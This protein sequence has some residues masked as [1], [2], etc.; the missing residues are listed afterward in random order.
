MEKK[1]ILVE[2]QEL[3]E[4]MKAND[5]SL[6]EWH[7]LPTFGGP[8]IEDTTGKWSWDATHYIE[9]TCADD[10]Q[11]VARDEGGEDQ[12][13]ND[14]HPK[15]GTWTGCVCHAPND[16]DLSCEVLPGQADLFSDSN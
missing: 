16:E 2:L 3:F 11:V 12:E 7:D 15:D 5:P 6:P 14:G 1:R 10:L 8:N 9:G 13:W 4:A